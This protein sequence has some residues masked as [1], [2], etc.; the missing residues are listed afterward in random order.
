MV[1]LIKGYTVLKSSGLLITK[2]QRGHDIIH[3]YRLTC[4]DSSYMVHLEQR[5]H[6]GGSAEGILY[7][8]EDLDK[9]NRVFARH[10]NMR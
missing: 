9:A 4:D 2:D 8:G 7:K 1:A 5:F 6:N 3:R 10:C